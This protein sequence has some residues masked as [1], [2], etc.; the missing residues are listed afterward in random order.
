MGR[1]QNKKGLDEINR[2]HDEKQNITEKEW[3]LL[4]KYRNLCEEN[5]LTID[6]L[7]QRLLTH[8]KGRE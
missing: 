6:I 7:I 3:A 8:Q 5:K 1:E 2:N 4:E